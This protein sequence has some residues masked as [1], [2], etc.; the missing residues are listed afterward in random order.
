MEENYHNLTIIRKKLLKWK[1]QAG[2]N[3]ISG[4]N[5][6]NNNIISRNLQW[7]LTHA[8]SSTADVS[9]PFCP[10]SPMESKLKSSVA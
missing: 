1:L 3:K 6:S 5:Y 7:K 8:L 2:K 4:K 10:E 9:E